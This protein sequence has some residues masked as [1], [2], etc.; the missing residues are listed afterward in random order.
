MCARVYV[1]YARI[2]YHLRLT[3]KH[4]I[5]MHNKNGKKEQK[6]KKKHVWYHI[7]TYTQNNVWFLD[8]LTEEMDREL[9]CGEQKY[10]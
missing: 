8:R 10:I 4:R 6:Q 5:P 9:K 2:A 7:H 1:V 3:S